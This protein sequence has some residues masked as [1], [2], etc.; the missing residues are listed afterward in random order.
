MV[1]DTETDVETGMK[2]AVDLALGQIGSSLFRFISCHKF[3]GSSLI[4][5]VLRPALRSREESACA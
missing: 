1:S 2:C 3:G 4:R 5:P